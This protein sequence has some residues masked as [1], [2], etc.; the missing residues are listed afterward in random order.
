MS[1]NSISL[2]WLISIPTGQGTY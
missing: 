2:T 1:N